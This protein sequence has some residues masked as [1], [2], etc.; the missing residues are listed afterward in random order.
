M[1]AL[2]LEGLLA[3]GRGAGFLAALE[4]GRPASEVVLRC[5]IEDPR[6]D[7]QVEARAEYYASLLIAQ[8]SSVAPI[9]DALGQRDRDD[10][11]LARAVLIQ[12][13]WRDHL[14]ALAAVIEQVRAGRMDA[15]DLDD[16]GGRTLV[17][18]VFAIAG[19][20]PPPPDPPRRARRPKLGLSLDV[21]QLVAQVTGPDHPNKV[22]AARRLG[23]LDHA[24]LVPDAYAFLRSEC[25]LTLEQRR[26]HRQRRAW[27]V[28]L[29]SLPAVRTLELARSWFHDEWPLCH[30]ARRIL[31]RHAEPEDRA[32]LEDAGA[33]AL[34]EHDVY[35]LCSVVDALA[36]LAD[37]RSIPLLA[38]IYQETD[39]SYARERV[40]TALLEHCE[41]NDA[42]ALLFESLWDCEAF[43]RG[44]A[45]EG[46]DVAAAAA[47]LHELQADPFER[48]EVRSAA[49]ARLAGESS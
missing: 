24:E 38:A 48:E 21:A 31:E 29:E 9:V 18:R 13:A 10:L 27:V 17:E 15:G 41:R 43:T 8:G 39:Y 4:R 11:W 32:M 33:K 7:R 19:R 46:V 45:C 25:G 20:S 30:A 14:G 40:C 35:L 23:E 6:W 49:R 26:G 5:V 3:R 34:V 16:E 37:P 2:D 28:Y 1:V 44:L 12:L 47:R 22:I 42:Q 36:G